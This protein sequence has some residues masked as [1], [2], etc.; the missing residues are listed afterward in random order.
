M[1]WSVGVISV[2][3]VGRRRYNDSTVGLTLYV[4][5][6]FTH[7]T[8]S[9]CGCTVFLICPRAHSDLYLLELLFHQFQY[10]YPKLLRL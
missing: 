2:I 4:L 10:A 6:Y 1:P 7:V 3:L 9:H 8:L 5:L